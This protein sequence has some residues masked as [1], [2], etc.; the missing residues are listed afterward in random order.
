MAV[1]DD[2]EEH[3]RGVGAVGE[4]ADLVDHEEA[5]VGVG[6]QGLG[7]APLA[8]G[9]G[10]IVD[11]LGGSREVRV[12]TVLD[13]SVGDRHRKVGFA[14]AGFAVEDQAVSLRDEARREGRAEQGKADSGLV[15]EVEVVDGFEEGE[16]GPPGEAPEACLLAMSDLLGDQ[17]RQEVSIGPLFLLRALHELAPDPAR[18]G[19][20]EPLEQDVELI[21][22]R[23][24]RR[25][26]SETRRARMPQEPRSRPR[27]TFGST[28]FASLTRFVEVDT[29]GAVTA[30]LRPETAT[31]PFWGPPRT[32]PSPPPSL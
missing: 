20:M 9:G 25:P 26:L 5:R 11:E 31:A 7:Q 18:V 29:D 22:G 28:P 21:V 14:A 13:G 19:E 30:G 6:G 15:G 10:Q 1:V 23:R 24:H 8:E 3:V 32:A 4:V 27:T 12:E 17:E 2:V 16:A